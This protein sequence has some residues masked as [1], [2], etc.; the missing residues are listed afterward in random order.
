MASFSDEIDDKKQSSIVSDHD[1]STQIPELEKLRYR[2]AG[3]KDEAERAVCE[4]RLANLD[5]HADLADR[6]Y[7]IAEAR[8]VD[9]HVEPFPELKPELPPDSRSYAQRVEAAQKE[10]AQSDRGLELQDMREER[11]EKLLENLRCFVDTYAPE[12]SARDASQQGP[13]IEKASERLTQTFDT[14]TRH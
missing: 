9:K 13:D 8:Y 7:K 1:Q 10:F 2:I 5:E 14:I 12:K 6:A 11:A 4:A 3:I